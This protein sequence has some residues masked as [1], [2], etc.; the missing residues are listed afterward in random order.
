MNP[1]THTLGST[2]RQLGFVALLV[3]TLATT[4]AAGTSTTVAYVT[5]FGAGSNDT[6]APPAT[7]GSSIFVNALTG[8]PPVGR[9]STADGTKTVT[10]V[11]V[12]LAAIDE[13]L[14]IELAGFDTIILYQVCDIGSH[15]NAMTAIN[16]FLLSGGK[17]LIF[18]A[19]RCAASYGSFHFPFTASRPAPEGSAGT[20]TNVQPSTLTTGL[21][22]GPQ[23]G[24]AVGDAN[25]FATLDGNWCGSI[26][27]TTAGG[28]AGFL[29]A[30]ARTSSGGLVIY[31]GEDFWF[32]SGP[33]PH[34]REVFDLMLQQNWNPDGLPCA[35]PASGIALSPVRQTREPGTRVGITVTVVDPNGV[36]Q[37]GVPVVLQVTAGP[38][39]GTTGGTTTDRS[40]RANFQYSTVGEGRDTL[41]ALFTDSAAGEHHSNSAAVLWAVANTPPTAVC[42]DVTVATTPGTC[43]API[44][45]DGGSFDP[46]AGD[47]LTRTQ[48]PPGPYAPG[49]TRVTLTVTDTRGATSSCRATVTVVDEEAPQITCPA[50]I[51]LECAG[52]DGATASFSATA[53]DNC[54]V[55]AVSCPGSGASFPV[56]TTTVGCTA[57]DTSH[58]SSAC[59]TT[60]TVVDTT[61]PVV[62]CVAGVNPSG[63]NVPA[64]DAAGFY[65]VSARDRCGAATLSFGGV[66]LNDGET[67]KITRPA[68]K[69]GVTLVNTM[70]PAEMKHFQ[71]GADARIEATDAAGNTA[72]V[73]CPAP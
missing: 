48:S 63:E 30:Y 55:A 11:D 44:S 25:Y 23:P 4:A 59:T 3:A 10:I 12:S 42:Q 15:P 5:E 16:N 49:T 39:R 62:T 57:T 43:L 19:D 73:T 31:A 54:V 7:P 28:R 21:V 29:Q 14:A 68:G 40:G 58:G 13:N 69:L 35:L 60:V 37:V 50:R 26:T 52:P 61:P 2:L 41:D 6:V 47:T 38:N 72:S 46:D 1:T 17:V 34:L 64:D 18:D 27:A 65:T 51:T 71:V 32:T 53:T 24:E 22:V 56:G 20:Y 33:T 45:V 9:Y 70:G 67:I 66:T 36:P 8:V